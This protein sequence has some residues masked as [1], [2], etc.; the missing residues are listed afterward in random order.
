M[1]SAKERSASF[2]PSRIDGGDIRA[3][4]VDD[5]DAQSIQPY[6]SIRKSCHHMPS[7]SPVILGADTFVQVIRE[8]RTFWQP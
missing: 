7:G 1:N 8:I 2:A 6:L 4:V 5:L 3:E